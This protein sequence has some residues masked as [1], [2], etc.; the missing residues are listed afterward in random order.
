MSTIAGTNIPAYIKRTNPW[1]YGE[2]LNAVQRVDG[3]RLSAARREHAKVAVLVLCG[4]P[5]TLYLLGFSVAWIRRGF[6]NA[7]TTR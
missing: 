6:Q 1:L 5:A 2:V 7:E 4:P 3:E